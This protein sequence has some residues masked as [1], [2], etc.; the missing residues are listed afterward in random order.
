MLYQQPQVGP[1]RIDPS[2]KYARTLKGLWNFANGPST[3]NL[4][5]GKPTILVGAPGTGVSPAG[6]G[7]TSNGSSSTYVDT[8]LLASSI[9]VNG[10]GARTVFAVTTL[11]VNYGAST[12]GLI[13]LGV[14]NA[15]EDWSFRLNSASSGWR[16]QIWGGASDD[17]SYGAI[18]DTVVVVAVYLPGTPTKIFINGAIRSAGTGPTTLNTTDANLLFGTWTWTGDSW[19]NPITVAGI[20]NRA[21]SDA[22]AAS[23]SA[24]PT[25]AWQLFADEDDEDVWAPAAS[26]LT[27]AIAELLTATDSQAA[28]FSAN[29]SITEAL[30][31][32]EAIAA[33]N[34]ATAS[35]GDTLTAGDS[36]SA[37]LVVATTTADTL[38]GAEV[39][40]AGAA[41]MATSSD[42]GAATDSSSTS[43]STSAA[44]ADILTASDSQSGA[45]AA[46]AST[47]ESGAAVDT[48]STAGTTNAAVTETLAATDTS[49]AAG[50]FATGR[51]D[52]LAASDTTSAVAAAVA[53]MIEA[54][55]AVD[56]TNGAPQGVL[57]VSDQ[58][59]AID[60]QAAAGSFQRAASDVLSA[61]DLVTSLA[62]LMT[63]ATGDSLSAADIT[64][65]TWYEGEIPPPTVPAS[66][67][68]VFDGGIRLIMFDGGTNRVTFDG[69]KRTVVFDVSGSKEGF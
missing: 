13:Q 53:V 36:C 40:A 55:T 63:A 29:V 54:L 12:S 58:L 69:G 43:G 19:A 60:A 15:S 24:S 52:T 30:A 2:N 21:W 39:T 42:T 3:A 48:V 4:I 11:P 41:M 67:T 22:D 66:R 25:N 5:T 34:A 50:S 51:I 10:N 44:T 7:F 33:S 46:T 16:V 64:G 59:A 45:M 57:T 61:M 27:A 26:G 37:T 65:A 8:G 17:F 38:A 1:Y 56:A 31:A 28:N 18:G 6:R 23:F 47:A 35:R 68:V 9:G 32:V 49:S 62:V 14:P 20:D